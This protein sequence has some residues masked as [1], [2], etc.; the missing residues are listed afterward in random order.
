MS[1]CTVLDREGNS[2]G[3]KVETEGKNDLLQSDAAKLVVGT[4]HLRR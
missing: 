4:S 1:S 2:P 3:I